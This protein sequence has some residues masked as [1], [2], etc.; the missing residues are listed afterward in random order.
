MLKDKNIVIGVSGGIAAYKV[1]E[2]VSRLKKEKANVDVIMTKHA[3]EFVSELTFRTLALSPVYT[4]MFGKPVN[5]DVEHISLAEKADIFLLAPATANLIGKIANGIADDLLTTTVMAT[6]A[7][8][9]LA[10][11]MNTH[12]YQNPITQDNMNRLKSLGYE[13]ITPG[14]GMLACQ[15]YGPGRMAE[16]IDIVEYLIKSLEDKNQDLKDKKVIVT[17]GPTIEEIDPVRYLTNYSS[18]KMGYEIAK[19]ARDRGAEVIL[20]SG[21]TNLE[22]PL[23]LKV[24]DIK[25]TSDMLE[26]IE[27]EFEDTDVLIKAAAVSDYRVKARSNKKIKKSKEEELTLELVE[28]EDIAAHF[29][30]KKGNRILVGFAAETNDLL[31]NARKKIKKKNLDFIVAN[32]VTKEGAGFDVDTNIVSIVDEDKIKEYPKMLKTEVADIILDKIVDIANKKTR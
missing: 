19:K 21:P 14:V 17:A 26:A 25:S 9:I 20:I 30:K 2:V 3:T 15:T 6:E 8:V 23:G 12:M 27:K 28:N 32:D 4:D 24:I 29:G 10:P 7:K 13:F 5:Y 18:G 22:K 11:A 1:V 31:E 16:P